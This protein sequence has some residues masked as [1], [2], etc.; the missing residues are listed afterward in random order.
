MFDTVPRITVMTVIPTSN[1]PAFSA[2]AGL[3][4]ICFVSERALLPS[5][6]EIV[7]ASDQKDTRLR[8]YHSVRCLSF[9]DC[10]SHSIAIKICNFYFRIFDCR[11]S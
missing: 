11:F 6:T 4:E 9:V 1:E 10:A 2:C 3:G 8:R 7:L 5:A